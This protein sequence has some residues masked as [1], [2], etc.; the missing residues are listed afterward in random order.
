MPKQ[1]ITSIVSTGNDSRHYI[2]YDIEFMYSAQK[3]H[4]KENRLPW[5][6][7]KAQ[8]SAKEAY[9]RLFELK[10]TPP[11]RGLWSFGTALTMEKKNSAALQNCAMVS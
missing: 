4:A 9:Q 6:D 7:Y 3:N 8:S 11:G 1:R 5:N 10:W 2:T